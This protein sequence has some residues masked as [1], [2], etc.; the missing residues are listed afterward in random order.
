[1]FLPAKWQDPTIAPAETGVMD[2]NMTLA[3]VTHNTSMILLHHR[4]GYPGP[5]LK[6]IKLESFYSAETCRLAAVETATITSKYLAVSSPYMPLSPHFSFCLCMSAR[7]LL[8]ELCAC[9]LCFCLYIL[10]T[11]M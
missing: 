10:L 7:V 5:Q 2:P 9:Y 1:M 6:R 4:I 11:V 3:H 8:G